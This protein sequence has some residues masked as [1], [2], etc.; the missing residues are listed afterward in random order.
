MNV[1]QYQNILGSQLVDY[2]GNALTTTA[3]NYIMNQAVTEYSRW[4]GLLRTYG[5]GGLAL[6]APIGSSTLTVVGGPY[7]G[8]SQVILD[9]FTPYAETVTVAAVSQ[10][11]PTLDPIPVGNPVLLT[12][13]SPTVN[14]HY[15]GGLVAVVNTGSALPNVQQY[16]MPLDFM[17]V[18]DNS[19]NITTGQKAAF[20]QYQGYYNSIYEFSS[21]AQGVDLGQAQNF[22]GGPFTTFIGV[23]AQGNGSLA[24]PWT[25]QGSSYVFTG[26]DQVILNILPI[27]QAQQWLNFNYWA[28]HL[29]ET[30]PSDDMDALIS[31]SMFIGIENNAVPISVYPDLRD[32]RQDV[33]WSGA[34]SALRSLGEVYLHK[35]DTAIRKRP[36]AI[37]G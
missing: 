15:A 11:D 14:L 13:S 37:S 16:P 35:F 5:I 12:L 32:I 31:Y 10:V 34:A 36:L 19:W 20:K 25:N 33:K 17:S 2:N 29:P 9:A 22:M 4:R 28:L 27:P 18:E 7:T 23:P 26:A 24:T 6:K 21:M 1:T 8:G 30:V 3:L